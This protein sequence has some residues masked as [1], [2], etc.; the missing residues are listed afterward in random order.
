MLAGMFVLVAAGG[1]F[2]L[3][4]RRPRPRR[5]LIPRRPPV[6]A[7]T[8]VARGTRP[9]PATDTAA[10]VAELNQP[11]GPDAD[12]QAGH[13]ASIAAALRR[14]GRTDALP[15]VIRCADAAA[16]LPCGLLLSAEAVGFPNFSMLLT[17]PARADRHA[18]YRALARTARGGRDGALDVG[19]LVRAGLLEHLADLSPGE[20][21]PWLAAAMIEAERAARR[22]EMW[23]KLLP[24]AER[25]HAERHLA[26]LTL[27]TER[28]QRWLRDASRRL[29]AN[30]PTAGDE[31]RAAT[32]RVLDDL[33]ADVSALFPSLP[34][35]RSSWWADAVRALRWALTRDYGPALAEQAERLL[36]TPRP[37]PTVA[38][39]LAGLRNA[40]SPG[41]ERV[42]LGGATHPDA[43]AR[44]A[45]V[46]AFG[47]AEPFDR[48]A[49]IAALHAARRDA[50]AN[51]RRT[52]VAALARFGEL[53]ALREYAQGL[54][55]E[56]PAVRQATALSAADEGVTWLW[57][58]LDL[59][60][61]HAEAETALA[62][63]EALERMREAA[64]GLVE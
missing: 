34:D 2:W 29:V 31:E 33:R 40:R 23:V 49:V 21:D 55:A 18:A 61:D 8:T 19:S 4:Y 11:V 30:F 15:A 20:P 43:N 36:F 6:P 41:V 1:L 39:V 56:D 47:W 51:V 64:L 7:N 62:A 3:A 28:R 44:C 54:L 38:A 45:A 48:T 46:A 52:A 63:A 9:L 60:A 50:D 13:R 58:D 25:E 14:V 22:G 24:A 27:S 53:A 17:S 37:G 16:G 32:L 59:V 12:E 26:R 35:R 57:P 10:L 5:W 42:L